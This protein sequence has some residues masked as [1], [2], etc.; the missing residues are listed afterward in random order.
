MDGGSGFTAARL[1]AFRDVTGAAS[2]PVTDLHHSIMAM[3]KRE[4]KSFS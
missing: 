4:G 3:G 2:D 1:F